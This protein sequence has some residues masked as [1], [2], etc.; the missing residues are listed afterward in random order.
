LGRTLGT[1]LAVTRGSDPESSLTTMSSAGAPSTSA[2]AFVA[3]WCVRAK[4]ETAGGAF[5]VREDEPRRIMIG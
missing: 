4:V 3:R 5:Q 1:V 2:S